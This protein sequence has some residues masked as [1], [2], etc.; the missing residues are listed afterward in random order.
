[1]HETQHFP[2]QRNVSGF[3]FLQPD[4]RLDEDIERIY[5]DLRVFALDPVGLR[6]RV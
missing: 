1:M 3:S 5:Q 6:L 2:S 4:L